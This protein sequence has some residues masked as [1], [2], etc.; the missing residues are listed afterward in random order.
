MNSS[1]NSGGA[2]MRVRDLTKTF[3]VSSSPLDR[4]RGIP[5]RAVKALTGV[6]LELLRGETLGIVG[7]SG[8]G[9]STLAR[10]LVRLY[11][12]DS[13]SLEYEGTNVLGLRGTQLRAYNRTCK[14]CF[15]I[16]SRA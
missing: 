3:P 2:I 1:L 10:C 9:K 5:P 4:V 6:N 15:K 11:D 13:G 8:C 16:P 12:A 7:E 14:W